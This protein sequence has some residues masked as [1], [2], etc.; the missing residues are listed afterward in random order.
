M[1]SGE[2]VKSQGFLELQCL[3]LQ[4]LIGERGVEVVEIR[5]S[6]TRW[7]ERQMAARCGATP[8]IAYGGGGIK[9]V[10]NLEFTDLNRFPGLRCGW[11]VSG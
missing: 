5:L 8:V 9:E 11:R 4:L 7:Q 3:P 2:L 6:T 1:A 10:L